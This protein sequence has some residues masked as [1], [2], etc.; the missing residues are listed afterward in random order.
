MLN[1]Y[2]LGYVWENPFSMKPESVIALFKQRLIDRQFHARMEG[3]FW[4]KVFCVYCLKLKF[5]YAPYLD[6][7]KTK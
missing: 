4:F 5:G 7:A 6:L 2:S 3:K 1:K